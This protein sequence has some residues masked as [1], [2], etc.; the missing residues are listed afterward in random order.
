MSEQELIEYEKKLNKGLEKSFEKMLKQKVLLGQDIV[1]TD[2]EG[3]VIEIS[4]KQAWEQLYGQL[5]E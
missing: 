1:T 2:G 4:A 5:P 3:N